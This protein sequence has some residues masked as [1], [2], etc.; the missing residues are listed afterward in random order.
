MLIACHIY[1]TLSIGSQTIQKQY[2]I[3]NSQ[4]CFGRHCRCESNPIYNYIQREKKTNPD[5]SD[6]GPKYGFL[7][8]LRFCCCLDMP[9][10]ARKEIVP[11]ATCRGLAQ[12]RLAK[13]RTCTRI[14]MQH[15]T[16]IANRH[17]NNLYV[18][19][20]SDQSRCVVFFYNAFVR[21]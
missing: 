21:L 16:E 18:G 8:C 5:W 15:I 19:P 14:V 11:S 4:M 6:I 3:D 17:N 20:T 1:D 2:E 13:Q 9:S 10:F 12:K 7:M